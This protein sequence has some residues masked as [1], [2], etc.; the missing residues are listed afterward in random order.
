MAEALTI[1]ASGD[2]EAA[3]LVVFCSPELFY[4]YYGSPARLPEL[5]TFID[6][7]ITVATYEPPGDWYEKRVK[8]RQAEQ[9]LLVSRADLGRYRQ[10]ARR[11]SKTAQAEIEGPLCAQDAI[12]QVVARTAAPIVLS[13][14]DQEDDL[15]HPWKSELYS[16]ATSHYL[17]QLKGQGPASYRRIVGLISDASY[18]RAKFQP[19]VQEGYQFQENISH[20]ANPVLWSSW[21]VDRVLANVDVSVNLRRAHHDSLRKLAAARKQWAIEL[22]TLQAEPEIEHIDNYQVLQGNPATHQYFEGTADPQS[23]EREHRLAEKIKFL[24]RVF[25][26]NKLRNQSGA[27]CWWV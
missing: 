13:V 17:S 8:V 3:K 15:V 10:E 22:G 27:L 25:T 9:E 7:R 4:R 14:H 23:V 21:R 26:G 1:Y 5:A 16:P 6:P 19:L 24:D 12:S 18:P 11:S 20:G 2:L